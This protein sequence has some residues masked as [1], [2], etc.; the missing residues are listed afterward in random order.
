[1]TLNGLD[2]LAPD[3]DNAP[4]QSIHVAVGAIDVRNDYQGDTL[5]TNL[6]KIAGLVIEPSP[7]S[8]IGKTLADLGYSKIALTMSVGASYQAEAKTFALTDFTI[9]GVDMGS[10]GLTADFTDVGPELFGADNSGRLL[11]AL[12]A[13]VAAVEIKLANGGLFEKALAFYAKQGGVTPDALRRN[14]RRWSDNR[15]R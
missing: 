9:D 12:G 6:S 15:L 8:D 7:G 3:P 14:G 4:G 1:M 5:K 10:L 2:I 11:A 13:G